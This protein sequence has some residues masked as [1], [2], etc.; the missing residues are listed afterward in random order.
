ML[1]IALCA[2]GLPAHGYAAVSE[3]EFQLRNTADFVNLC[4]A[5]GADPL[6]VAAVSL[7]QG[8]AMGVYRV[9]Q[10]EDAARS[11]GHLF[12]P[13]NPAPTRNQELANFTQWARASPDRLAQS[14]QDGIAAYLAQQHP[15]PGQ[16]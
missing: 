1:A 14:P 4:N 12:C 15:C 7:C 8:F 10:E 2:G 16:K 11:S 6:G 5:P 9:L 13:R 3:E